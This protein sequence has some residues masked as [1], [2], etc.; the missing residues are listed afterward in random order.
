MHDTSQV[1]SALLSIGQ[2]DISLLHSEWNYC[3]YSENVW[4]ASGTAI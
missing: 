2:M 3:G 1:K 4:S